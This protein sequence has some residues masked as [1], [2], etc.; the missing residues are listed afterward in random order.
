MEI[1]EIMMRFEN[2]DEFVER[3]RKIQNLTKE[4][5]N[6]INLLK[7]LE[8]K[9]YKEEKQNKL[10]DFEKERRFLIP[11]LGGRLDS[12]VDEITKQI[13]K[14]N[15]ENS[16]TILNELFEYTAKKILTEASIEAY[17]REHKRSL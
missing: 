9:L 16:P 12:V 3:V 15:I 14:C 1:P 4:L 11:A 2:A 8:I 13:K 7:G 10:M 5:E 17:Q 6:E